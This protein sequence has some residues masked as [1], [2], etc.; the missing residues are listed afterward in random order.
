MLE[1]KHVEYVQYDLIAKFRNGDCAVGVHGRPVAL[2]LESL[3]SLSG[4]I[5]RFK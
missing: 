5:A 1:G 3:A 4:F 2:L